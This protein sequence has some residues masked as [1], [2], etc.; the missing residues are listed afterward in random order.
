MQFQIARVVVAHIWC[1]VVLAQ[2]F[3][4]FA[5]GGIE[6]FAQSQALYRRHAEAG[7]CNTG[8]APKQRC[9]QPFFHT[10]LSSYRDKIHVCVFEP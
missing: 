5:F 6:R 3:A 7:Q 1:G 4:Q 2:G 10:I 9:H 8:H